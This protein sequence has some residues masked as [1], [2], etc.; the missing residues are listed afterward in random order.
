[1]NLGDCLT[2]LRQSSNPKSPMC[3]YLKIK[4]SQYVNDFACPPCFAPVENH[5]MNVSYKPDIPFG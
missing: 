3:S 1:M 5:A 4:S 2:Y